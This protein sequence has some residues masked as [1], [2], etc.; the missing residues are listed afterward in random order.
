MLKLN[1]AILLLA[2]CLVGCNRQDARHAQ[3]EQDVASDITKIKT[4]SASRAK[5]F[6]EGNADLIAAAFTETG[7]LMAPG[8]KSTTG[9]D[10]VREYYQN[11][12][13]QYRTVL[14]SGYE[15]VKVSGDVGYGVGFAKVK[16]V[17]HSGGDTLFSTAK[18]INILQ[19]QRDGSW[20]TTHDIWN[21][22]E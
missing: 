19:R 17:P 9:R 8:T 20:L 10:A 12:F 3:Y 13:D 6:N 16:L 14:E 7:L 5:A 22:N 21:G 18:Y 11:I 15:E 4:L 1:V 2:I